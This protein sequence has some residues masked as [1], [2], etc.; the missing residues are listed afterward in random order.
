MS[1]AE[2][3]DPKPYTLNPKPKWLWLKPFWLKTLIVKG[4]PLPFCVWP[5]FRLGRSLGALLLG[6]LC[7]SSSSSVTWVSSQSV[8]VLCVFCDLGEY[9]VR[10]GSSPALWFGVGFWFWLVVT[11]SSWSST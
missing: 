10:G 6:R 7:G 3:L 1:L 2:T 9:A 11:W 5:W 4:F 8:R